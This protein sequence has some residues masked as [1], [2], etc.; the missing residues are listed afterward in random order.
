MKIVIDTNVLISAILKDRDPERVL[1]FAASQMGV[2]WVVSHDILAEYKKVL[3]RDKFQL[4]ATLLLQ[5]HAIFEAKTSLI[6][7]GVDIDF[8]R[9][10]NDAKFLICAISAGA[11]FFITGDRDFSGAQKLLKTTIISVAEFI[12]LVVEPL[13]GQPT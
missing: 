7:P 1:L 10:Q 8:P 9:D 5:W 2:E 12:R 13:T 11:D 4:P 3:A 6:A